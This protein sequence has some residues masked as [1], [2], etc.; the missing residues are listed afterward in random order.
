MATFYRWVPKR[1]AQS[2]L[3]SGLISHHERSA[4]WIFS[5][6]AEYDYRP[7]MQS[8]REN[9]EPYIL[10]AYE[11]DDTG[12]ASLHRRQ[13]NFEAPDFLGEAGYPQDVIVKNNERGAF[14]LGKGR[15]RTTDYHVTRT[16]YASREEV[17]KALEISLRNTNILNIFKPPAG[18]PR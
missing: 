16:R 3:E 15:Q 7:S 1:F 14:G 10:I 6:A 2:A 17:A 13:V 5:M 12:T 18:W 9:G 8:R 11:L 4:M